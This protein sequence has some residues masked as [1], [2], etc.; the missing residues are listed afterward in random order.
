[1][2]QLEAIVAEFGGTLL[3]GGRRALIPGPRHSRRD[4]SVSLTECEDG[5]ILIYCFSPRDNWREVRDMLASRKLLHELAASG[6]SEPIHDAK[7]EAAAA[8]KQKRALSFWNEARPI[9]WTA[10]E[11]YLQG[12]SIHG[13]MTE[14]ALRFHPRMTSI[15]DFNRRPALLAALLDAEGDLQGIQAILLAPR[16]AGKARVATPKRVIGKLMGGAVRLCPA[17]ETL[18]IA[19]GIETALSA[20]EHF[21]SLIHI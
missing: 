16:G 12:R 14:D 7:A 10:A 5:R 15:D 17:G 3:D 9:A 8:T 20:S 21:L 18:I 19:E 11:L 13:G 1:M 6:V 2:S 4:R